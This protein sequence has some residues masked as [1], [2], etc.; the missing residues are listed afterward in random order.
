MPSSDMILR[1]LSCAHAWISSVVRE[2]DCVLDG[3]AGNGHDTLFL[4]KAVGESG[5]VYAFDIQAEA[6]V[7]TQER[8]SLEGVLDRVSLYTCN[9]AKLDRYVPHGLSAAMFNLGYLPGGDKARMTTASDTIPALKKAFSLLN[10]G[11]ILTVMCYPGHEGGK[12]E[13]QAVDDFC[14]EIPIRDA[15]VCR[16]QSRNGAANAPFL[17]GIQKR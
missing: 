9:H 14:A 13:A 4:A 6:I 17:I 7:A 15:F 11:G 8:L 3:T 10:S 2:G 16:V 12:D 5:K 1:P